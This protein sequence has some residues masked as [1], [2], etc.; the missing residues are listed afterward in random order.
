MSSCLISRHKSGL[1][2]SPEGET[3][4]TG[5]VRVVSSVVRK[6]KVLSVANDQFEALIVDDCPKA[7]VS[8]LV[9]SSVRKLE[10]HNRVAGHVDRRVADDGLGL[11][12]RSL[13]NDPGA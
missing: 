6:G 1:T 12:S 4:E 2:P 3:T 7:D 5:G 13:V 11:A 10:R 8:V 9:H